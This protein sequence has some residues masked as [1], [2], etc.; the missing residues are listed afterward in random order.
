MADVLPLVLR[1]LLSGLTV[2]LV[3]Y[4]LSL[5]AGLAQLVLR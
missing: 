2:A 5:A 3:I 1:H 4:G